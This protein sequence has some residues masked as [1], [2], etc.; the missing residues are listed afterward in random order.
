MSLK[1]KLLKKI[2]DESGLEF[3]QFGSR[4]SKLSVLLSGE[5][6][7]I[8]LSPNVPRDKKGRPSY[9]ND[10]LGA[11][12]NYESAAALSTAINNIING[13]AEADGMVMN[14]NCTDGTSIVLER[15]P[16]REQNG[17]LETFLAIK[18]KDEIIPFKFCA[19][20]CKA[21]ENGK[22]VT[23]DEFGLE[24]F[25][26]PIEKYLV[27]NC[28]KAVTEHRIIYLDYPEYDAPDEDFNEI[29]VKRPSVRKRSPSG[30]ASRVRGREVQESL[31]FKTNILEDQYV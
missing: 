20:E 15:R 3:Y 31:P 16:S 25:M 18:K 27:G 4:L 10:G 13:K 24:N 14:I 12:V 7:H 1:S 9:R 5:N 22:T 26:E 21:K 30:I 17:Q 19:M 29:R 8:S 2:R 23:V 11:I 28:V 6:L